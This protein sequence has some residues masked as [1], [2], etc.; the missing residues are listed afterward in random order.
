MKKRMIG[1]IC[2]GVLAG[3]LLAGCGSDSE[4][5]AS[6]DTGSAAADTADTTE[7]ADAADAEYTLQ[8]QTHDPEDSATGR[9][10]DA[11]EED[12]EERSD[13]RIDIQIYY[14][15]MLGTASET[16][17]MVRSGTCDIGWGLQSYYANIF[18]VTEVFQLPMID[19]DSAAQGSDAIWNFYNDYDY[20]AEEYADYHVL[21]LHA[22]CQSP[23]STRDLMI[24]SIEDFEGLEIRVNFGPQSD[25][26]SNLGASSLSCEMAE[27]YTSLEDGVA[28]GCI[29]DFHGIMSFDLD[30]TI[31]YMLDANVGVSTYFMLMN[32]DSYD[33][34]P[35]DLQ[36]ILDEA[37]EDALA[38]TT[39]WDTVEEEQREAYAD[40]LYTL[41]EDEMERLQ[42]IADQTIE[43]WIDSMT[44]A[45]YDGQA[46]YDD[47]MAEI[48]AA[49]Q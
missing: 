14:D 44:E 20:M 2:I 12:V 33:A 7:A 16:L 26:V 28:D 23:I 49:A 41:E 34:L 13:G 32:Q 30:E 31:A 40:K 36:T 39:E 18:P 37:S 46:I 15:G 29:T 47:A 19:I 6:E 4:N 3:G 1:I 42:E 35:E 22:N 11:W 10:L 43:E 45:G 9:F 21:V 25:F 48:E 38:Y 24:E 8:V 5:S 27:L 17:D